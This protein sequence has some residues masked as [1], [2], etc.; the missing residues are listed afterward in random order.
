MRLPVLI[1]I[2]ALVLAACGEAPP[3][4]ARPAGTPS[5]P[6]SPSSAAPAAI[7]ASFRGSWDV[8]GGSCG[9]NDADNALTLQPD[10]L[11]FYESGGEV[12]A[13]RQTAPGVI[14][15]DA[16][17]SGEGETW[18]ATLSFALSDDGATLTTTQAGAPPTVRKRCQPE[19]QAQ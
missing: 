7:P 8:D 3:A 10:R 18:T 5:A 2:A 4:P 15:V 17:L 9:V 1:T 19:G 11:S 6:Q 14:E 12:T 13:V 16:A